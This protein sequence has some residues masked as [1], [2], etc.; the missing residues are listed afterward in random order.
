MIAAL[1]RYIRDVDDEGATELWQR[2]RDSAPD[3]R[4]DEV[5]WFIDAKAGKPGI[6]MP[7]GFL[8]TAVPKC[9]QG[10]AFRQFRKER[11]RTRISVAE[12]DRQFAA[13]VLKSPE[14]DE[15]QRQWARE[16]LG[17]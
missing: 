6:R 8:L 11:E 17:L 2:C 7:L 15:E 13:E 3:A 14:A 5:A 10:E 12:R 9:F 16:V 1:R 4:P